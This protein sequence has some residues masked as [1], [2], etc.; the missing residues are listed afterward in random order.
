MNYS[1][2]QHA[3]ALLACIGA[4]SVPVDAILARIDSATWPQLLPLLHYHGIGP[5]TYDTL[6]RR[7]HLGGLPPDIRQ[8]IKAA[9][10]RNAARN[11]ILFAQLDHIL[12][13]CQ[14]RSIPII[15]LK[16]AYLARSIYADP[17]LRVMGDIDIQVRPE[18]AHQVTEILNANGYVSAW[19]GDDAWKQRSC[20]LPPFHKTGAY[21]V[22]V[23]IDF[24]SPFTPFRTA[25]AD[26][27]QRAMV[28]SGSKAGAVAMTPTDLL[29]Y[30]CI[31]LYRTRLRVGLRHLIDL[32][33]VLQN[34]EEQIE[35]KVLIQR[36]RD[37]NME[38]ILWIALAVV[39]DILH[40]NPPAEMNPPTEYTPD[41]SI[42]QGIRHRIFR[43]ENPYSAMGL[44]YWGLQRISAPWVQVETYLPRGAPADQKPRRKTSIAHKLQLVTTASTDFI[45]STCRHPRRQYQAIQD[46]LREQRFDRWMRWP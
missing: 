22:E 35:P 45:A 13:A 16:G 39:E 37:W 6:R 32:K 10:E 14:A 7:N 23:H 18:D 36:A 34:S 26:I 20:H 24:K 29:L 41:P 2:L 3:D 11:M 1:H 17:A 38:R 9:Y 46:T 5:L 28:T 12:G 30:L 31:H 33:E 27:W 42:L 25:N 4:D 19:K 44:L 8:W 21:P 40:V 15:P 43:Q